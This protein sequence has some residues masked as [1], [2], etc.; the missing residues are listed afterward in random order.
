MVIN[1]S[2][3]TLQSSRT[4]QSYMQTQTASVVTRGSEGVSL[5][6]SD[7]SMSLVEQMNQYKEQL[8]QKNENGPK[9]FQN[10]IAAKKAKAPSEN[11]TSP[12]EDSDI[13]LLRKMLEALEEMRKGKGHKRVKELKD[14]ELPKKTFTFGSLSIKASST[15]MNT[16]LTDLRGTVSAA[17]GTG[18]LFT[19]TTAIS[20][21]FS[22]HEHTTFTGT[23]V[24]ITADGKKIEFGVD[25]EM[26]RAFTAKYEALEHSSYIMT[27]P[28]V[29]NLEDGRTSLTD[30]KY[31]FDLDSDG[32]MEEMSFTDKNSGFLA[33]DKNGDGII[34]NG[35]ELFGTKSGDGFADLA[36]YDEDKN[37]WIDEA[38]SVF[39]DLKV[40]TKDEN[41]NDKLV[42]L[43]KADVGAIYLGSADTEFSLKEAGTNDTNGVIRKTGVYLKESGGVG[44]VSH[45]DIAL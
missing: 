44:T 24:A 11:I 6:L 19:K 27:D 14:V 2:S 37:G 10:T 38:D 16:V 1:S 12:A 9:L 3:V 42:D 23:G 13:I 26:S 40:W 22:E 7:E 25:L 17:A 35:N 4:Y 21:V 28:L 36:E 8:N 39:K 33:L 30:K 18:T 29:I 31:L 15:N 20:S 5:E 41:G 43:L 34:N 32:D 45:V